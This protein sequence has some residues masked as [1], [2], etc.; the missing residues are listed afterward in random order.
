MGCLAL[1]TIPETPKSA[2]HGLSQLVAPVCSLTLQ[3][4]SACTAFSP[5]CSSA[6]FESP[7]PALLPVCSVILKEV[8]QLEVWITQ[9]HMA[10]GV[11]HIGLQGLA[12]V[13]LST[14]T[15]L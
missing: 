4:N 15:H 13:S 10:V 1:G 11:T 6:T 2:S 9:Q 5:N 3:S 12:Q 14:L 7:P 8:W